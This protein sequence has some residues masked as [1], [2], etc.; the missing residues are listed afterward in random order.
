MTAF[1][2]GTAAKVISQLI[3]DTLQHEQM[4][5]GEH[6]SDSVSESVGVWAWMDGPVVLSE[7]AGRA[8]TS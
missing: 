6:V 5:N 4:Q 7:S 2:S 8:K 1:A 3:A